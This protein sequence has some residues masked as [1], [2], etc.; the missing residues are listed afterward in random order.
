MAIWLDFYS[1]FLFGLIDLSIVEQSLHSVGVEGKRIYYILLDGGIPDYPVFLLFGR[2]EGREVFLGISHAKGC[3][4]LEAGLRDS[5]LWWEMGKEMGW[6]RR[7]VARLLCF[8]IPFDIY[9]Q[10]PF[11]L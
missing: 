2:N 5:V 9:L 4:E 6:F 3:D 8:C 10:V 11:F 7:D 1:T